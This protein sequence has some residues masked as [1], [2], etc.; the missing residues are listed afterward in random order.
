MLNGLPI[1]QLAY[2]SRASVWIS[3]T[4]LQTILMQ[5]RNRNRPH[6]ITGLLIF[7]D[8]HFLQILEGGQT[9]VHKT[10]A[11]IKQDSRHHELDV[12]H[13]QRTESRYFKSW[14]MGYCAI[15][16]RPPLYKHY[17]TLLAKPPAERQ[18]APLMPALK[19]YHEACLLDPR[20]NTAAMTLLDL[21][22]QTSS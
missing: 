12:F 20:L 7:C 9:D 18:L 11:R 19:A 2:I 4:D 6:H 22:M 17:R 8:G 14:T 13:I 21:P 15:H 1:L 3:K 10:M 5:S 16:K